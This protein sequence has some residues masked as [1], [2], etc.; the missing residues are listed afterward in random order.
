MFIKIFFLFTFLTIYVSVV[1]LQPFTF[2]PNEKNKHK[3]MVQSLVVPEE[4]ESYEQ[5]VSINLSFYTFF[6]PLNVYLFVQWKDVTPEQLMDSKLRC[7][8]EMPV[9]KTAKP[10]KPEVARSTSNYLFYIL[11]IAVK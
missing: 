7:V 3:F 2:D 9:D 11:C 1:C 10:A 4:Y 8:F 6:C 5:L